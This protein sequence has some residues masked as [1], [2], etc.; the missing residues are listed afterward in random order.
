MEI[1]YVRDQALAGMCNLHESM[2]N[3]HEEVAQMSIVFL[4]LFLPFLSQ[5][6][7][8]SFMGSSTGAVA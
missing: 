8:N 7:H 4:L 6:T 3:L 5:P 2:Y 1:V